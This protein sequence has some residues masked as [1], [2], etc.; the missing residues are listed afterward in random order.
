VVRIFYAVRDQIKYDPYSID[1]SE[2][3]FKAS[4]VL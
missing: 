2:E 3:K 1:L 4:V